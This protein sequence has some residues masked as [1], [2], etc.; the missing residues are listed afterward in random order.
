MLTSLSSLNL[1]I[2]QSLQ[3]IYRYYIQCNNEVL[4]VSVCLHVSV[5]MYIMLLQRHVFFHDV[6]YRYQHRNTGTVEHWNG[7][8][9]LMFKLMS[10]L[11]WILITITW[12]FCLQNVAS[13]YTMCQLTA[14]IYAYGVG[15]II[16]LSQ[17]IRKLSLYLE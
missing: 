10:G 2:L 15:D 7:I 8:P 5:V 9:M 16:V 3:E 4:C 17:V 6:S 14:T 1:Q 13:V 12:D 11:S